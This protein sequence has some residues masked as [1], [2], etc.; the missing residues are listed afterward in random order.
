MTSL[1]FSSLF[2]FIFF[3]FLLYNMFGIYLGIQTNFKPSEFLYVLTMDPSKSTY[4]V[5]GILG[6]YLFI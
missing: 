6:L 5:S 4:K 2:S 1:S 3:C